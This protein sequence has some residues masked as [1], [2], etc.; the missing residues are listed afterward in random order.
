M[1]R[2]PLTVQVRRVQNR[3]SPET[4]VVFSPSGTS[5]SDRSRTPVPLK[6]AFPIAARTA[7][8]PPL[9]L[10]IGKH[11]FFGFPISAIAALD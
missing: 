9:N 10:A 6:I 8:A 11:I 5:G 2:E 3:S 7:R 1:G 4:C